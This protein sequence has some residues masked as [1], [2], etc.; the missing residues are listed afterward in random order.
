MEPNTSVAPAEAKRIMDLT[1]LEQ[2]CAAFFE[3]CDA[4]GTDPSEAEQESLLRSFQGILAWRSE[5]ESAVRKVDGVIDRAA[6][7]V[8]ATL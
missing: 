6:A 4:A 5:L 3:A 2:A 1:R 8:S 7:K